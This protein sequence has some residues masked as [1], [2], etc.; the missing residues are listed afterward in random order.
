MLFFLEDH[1]PASLFGKI[2][3]EELKKLSTI[4]RLQAQ[5]EIMQ[6]IAGKLKDI[7]NDS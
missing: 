3:G 6:L 2:V 7:A 1:D 5:I 4:F